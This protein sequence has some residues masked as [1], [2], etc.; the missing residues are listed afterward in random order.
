MLQLLITAKD[1]ASS[2]FSKV[3]KALNDNTNVVGSKIRDGF[4]NLFGGSC[5][6]PDIAPK[7][8]TITPT[9]QALLKRQCLTCV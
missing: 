5:P 1:E 7:N 4:S 6:C 8:G 3:F 2:V 9:Q